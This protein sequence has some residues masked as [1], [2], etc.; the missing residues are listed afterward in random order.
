MLYADVVSYMEDPSD[1]GLDRII[2]HVLPI[3]A[4]FARK[5]SFTWEDREEA[6]QDILNHM[7]EAVK[8]VRRI[9]FDSPIRQK[10]AAGFKVGRGKAFAMM[11]Q[12]AK[13]KACDIVKSRVRRYRR[14][15]MIEEAKKLEA[16]LKRIEI[17]ED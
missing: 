15:C 17:A 4:M 9:R 2:A 7:V 13:G 3:A 5:I 1:A 10:R 12:C 16:I 6:E 11:Y 8:P 14:E